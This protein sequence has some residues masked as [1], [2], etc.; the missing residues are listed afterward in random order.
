M[1]LSLKPTHIFNLREHVGARDPREQLR[2]LDG[3]A[4]LQA[5]QWPR[6][7]ASNFCIFFLRRLEIYFRFGSFGWILIWFDLV[8]VDCGWFYCWVGWVAVRWWW[9]WAVVWQ[10]NMKKNMGVI[11]VDFFSGFWFE[12]KESEEWVYKLLEFFFF[13]VHNYHWLIFLFLFR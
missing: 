11:V 7:K 6:S 12:V 3:E 2:C 1:G 4:L 9:L 13:W 10:R 8:S 5:W